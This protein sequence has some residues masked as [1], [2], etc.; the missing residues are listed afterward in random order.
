MLHPTTTN[1][2]MSPDN[3]YKGFDYQWILTIDE[4]IQQGFPIH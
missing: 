3:Y 2:A 1:Q 4:K